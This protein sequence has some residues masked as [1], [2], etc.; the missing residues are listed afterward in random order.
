MQS[1]SIECCKGTEQC[2]SSFTRPGPLLYHLHDVLH[3]RMPDLASRH[4]PLHHEVSLPYNQ[5]VDKAAI[6]GEEE[7][8]FLKEMKA[9][10]F[11]KSLQ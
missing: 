10:R 9:A 4:Q 6:G 7:A 3:Q 8:G 1:N 11:R 2:L 5:D